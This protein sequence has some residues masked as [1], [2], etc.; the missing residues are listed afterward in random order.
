MGSF[1]A[2]L[3]RGTT[4]TTDVVFGVSLLAS[5]YFIWLILSL[6]AR[7]KTEVQGRSPRYKF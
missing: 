7:M 4:V 5:V 2:T 6:V 3:I 1:V